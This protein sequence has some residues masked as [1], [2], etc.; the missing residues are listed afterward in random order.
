[1]LVTVITQLK[2]S[3]ENAEARTR[4][5]K[6]QLFMYLQVIMQTEGMGTCKLPHRAQGPLITIVI[7][8]V[9][10][11]HCLNITLATATFSIVVVN[12]EIILGCHLI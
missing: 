8:M 12:I 2:D 11:Y 3:V 5:E 7:T 9:K 10:Q 1:M 4:H 6:T